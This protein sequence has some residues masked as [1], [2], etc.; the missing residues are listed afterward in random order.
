MAIDA[1]I[2]PILLQKI[3][4]PGNSPC[5]ADNGS[6]RSA[7]PRRLSC[8][9]LSETSPAAA[10]RVHRCADRFPPARREEASSR[11]NPRKALRQA[12]GCR[13]AGRTYPPEAPC[14][15]ARSRS[16]NNRDC[17]AEESFARAILP[18]GQYPPSPPPGA[19]PR[20]DP[21]AA[22]PRPPAAPCSANPPG[23]AKSGF[24]IA[25]PKLPSA[26]HGPGDADRKSH[27]PSRVNPR[28]HRA[29][30]D[31]PCPHPPYPLQRTHPHRQKSRHPDPLPNPDR[32]HPW[33][34]PNRFRCWDPPQSHRPH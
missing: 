26:F 21:P 8:A 5:A 22:A 18:R 25:G 29:C 12:A 32:S 28:H 23:C 1:H 17:R 19:W 2:R 27:R 24:P 14:A 4:N 9:H 16:T 7:E 11:A 10:V 34:S 33:C 3:Q 13:S 15:R 30:R 20:S 6:W 31:R